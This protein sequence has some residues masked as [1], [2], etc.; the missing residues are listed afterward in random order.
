MFFNL[1]EKNRSVFDPFDRTDPIDAHHGILRSGIS[2]GH[3]DE[4]TVAEN[5]ISWDFAFLSEL[6]PKRCEKGKEFLVA[7]EIV[8]GFA[9]ARAAGLFRHKDLFKA[10]GN[11]Q[12][13]ISPTKNRILPFGPLE[14]TLFDEDVDIVAKV[15]FRMVGHKIVSG[16]TIMA[17]I[18]N[19]F[20]FGAA[21]NIDDVF[22]AETL[23]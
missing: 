6:C 13:E 8:F 9:L 16:E 21:K 4:S 18:I 11:L 7:V 19:L 2:F 1:L 23:I 20:E 5:D 14:K 22:G 10:F 12:R 3:F 15:R 17:P